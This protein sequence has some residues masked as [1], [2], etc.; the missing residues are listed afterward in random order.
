MPQVLSNSTGETKKVSLFVHRD[1]MARPSR[2]WRLLWAESAESD[3]FCHAEG[4][5]SARHFP[6]MREAVRYGETAY[7]ETAKRFIDPREV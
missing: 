2:C 7:G 5:C 3:T 4:E 1:F 6:T